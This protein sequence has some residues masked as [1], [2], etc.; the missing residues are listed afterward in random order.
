MRRKL[1]TA[2]LILFFIAILVGSGEV[3]VQASVDRDAWRFV[4]DLV[5][6][7]FV[8]DSP[9][10]RQWAQQCRDQ[11]QVKLWRSRKKALE[12]LRTFLY[13]MEVSH[14][15]VF[16]P[17]EEHRIWKGES[18]DTGLRVLGSDGHFIVFRVIPQSPAS[19]A[20]IERGDEIVALN[21]R[22]IE[23]LWQSES[24]SGEFR[25]RHKDGSTRDV[26]LKARALLLD[27]NPKLTQL[28]AGVGLLEIPSFRGPLFEKW[29]DL[30]QKLGQ[31]Q[32]IVVD[33]RW[34]AG[35]NFAAMLRALSS[36]LCEPTRV[37]TLH[38][39]RLPQ[40]KAREFPNDLDDMTQIKF[41]EQS[42]DVHLVS[43]REYGCFKG[44]VVVL[45]NEETASAA[46]VFADAMSRR[47]QT[48]VMGQPTAGDVL[49]AVWYDIPQWGSG[50][51]LSIPESIYVNVRNQ[52]LEHEGVWP[53][54]ELNYRAD[55][56][57]KGRDTWMEK[58]L[59]EKF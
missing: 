7:R 11:A 27:E 12:E 29:G 33:L 44:P 38:Q 4:C 24:Q 36:F 48:R 46:E 57:L 28:R 30:G 1:W 20:G 13:K 53:G 50:Y 16:E 8:K 40:V 18:V 10:L 17:A 6:E 35:G 26:R 3:L 32:K 54:A 41:M 55:D 39:P 47:L 21:G 59:A 15:D 51:S 42:G 52:D 22:P 25:I 45:I 31:F 34:N 43:W 2:G 5:E 23:E 9:K 56:L 58:A 14:L 19:E 37:G 49:L